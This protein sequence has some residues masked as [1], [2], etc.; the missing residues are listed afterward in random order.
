ML[1]S[2]NIYAYAGIAFALDTRDFGT[3]CRY[4]VMKKQASLERI[5]YAG[6]ACR[7]A[8]VLGQHYILSTLPVVARRTAQPDRRSSTQAAMPLPAATRR[9]PAD[10]WNLRAPASLRNL[11][12]DHTLVM[13][14]G[15]RFNN[16]H[17]WTSRRGVLAR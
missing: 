1:I 16:Y 11:S 6:A 7:S 10:G 2:F 12:P 8:I 5:G 4:A 9:L 3:G 15:K 14:N 17:S 13:V